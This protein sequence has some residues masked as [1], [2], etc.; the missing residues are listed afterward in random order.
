[1]S[2]SMAIV[3]G[4]GLI[5]FSAILLAFSF[6]YK[7]TEGKRIQEKLVEEYGK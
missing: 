7:K 1:M 6:I 4:I 2:G 3:V 5:V